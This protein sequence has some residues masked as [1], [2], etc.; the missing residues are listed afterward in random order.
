MNTTP[1]LKDLENFITPHYAAQWRQIGTQ[2]SLPKGT[3][4]IIEHDNFH[5]AEL[6]CN[7]MWERWLELDSSATWIKLLDI[8]HSPA[9]SSTPA[10]EKGKCNTNVFYVTG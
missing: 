9:V 7:A 5:K 6:C 10:Y 3:L 2:L 8:V 4:D 1:L